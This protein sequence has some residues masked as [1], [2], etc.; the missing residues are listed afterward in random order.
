M[1]TVYLIIGKFLSIK[2][3]AIDFF[4]FNAGLGINLSVR[5]SPLQITNY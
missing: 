3:L 4:G 2:E 5:D 1:T